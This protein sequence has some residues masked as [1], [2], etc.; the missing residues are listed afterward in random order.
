MALAFQALQPDL[1]IYDSYEALLADPEIDAVY[2]PL[3]NHM[4]IEWTLKALDA[5][6]HVLCEKPLAMNAVDF[7]QVSQKRITQANC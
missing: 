1:K 4:H 3:P 7:D 5:G 2:V 6:K